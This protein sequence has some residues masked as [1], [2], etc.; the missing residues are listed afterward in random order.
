MD[1]LG[2]VWA[3]GTSKRGQLGLGPEV[4]QTLDA[5]LVPGLEGICQV[6]CGWGHAAAISSRILFHTSP[7]LGLKTCL[8]P[9]L[10]PEDLSS[11]TCFA[12]GG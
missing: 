3:W 12:T 11:T 8:A 6:S 1:E 7:P 5:L 9:T 4:V 10:D 2:R